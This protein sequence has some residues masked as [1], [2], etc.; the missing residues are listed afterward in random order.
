MLNKSNKGMQCWKRVSLQKG[1]PAKVAVT[2]VN[3]M[4][5]ES[6]TEAAS[7]ETPRQEQWRRKQN[8]LKF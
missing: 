6:Q 3:Q 5:Q 8:L 4:L 1:H 2:S 7:L